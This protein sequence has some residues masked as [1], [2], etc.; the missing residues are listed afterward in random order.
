VNFESPNPGL[1][2]NRSHSSG[3]GSWMANRLNQTALAFISLADVQAYCPACDAIQP[4]DVGKLID[5]Y[6]KDATLDSIP[7]QTCMFCGA[8]GIEL[9]VIL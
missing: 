7:P 1:T 2:F 6:G 5:R 4:V 9:D 8:G 3:T